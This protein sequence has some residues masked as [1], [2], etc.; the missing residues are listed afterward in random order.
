MKKLFVTLILLIGFMSPVCGA[1]VGFGSSSLA[2]KGGSELT[3]LGR[4]MSEAEFKQMS[5]TGRV[6]EGAGGRTSVISPPNPLSFK[7]PPSSTIYAEFNVPSSVLRQGG[8]ADWAIIPGPNIQTRMFGPAPAQM[9]PATC[10]VC[11]IRN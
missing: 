2:A 3:K 5:A 1:V 11:V 7:P 6:V 10:I 4:W 9:P 8:K